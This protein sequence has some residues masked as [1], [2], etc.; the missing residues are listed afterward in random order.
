MKTSR[1][2]IRW[3]IRETMGIVFLGVALFVSAGSINWPMGWALLIITSLWVVGTALVLIPN[4]P[5]LIAERLGPRKGAKKWDTT[6][7]SVFGLTVLA[8]LVVAGLDIRFGWSEDVAFPLQLGTLVLAILANTLV[9]WATAA[10]AFFSQVVRIQEERA[11]QV[12]TGGPYRFVRHPGYVGTIL[13]ELAT[14]I[15]LGSWWALIPGC[16]GALLMLIRTA[17]EDHTLKD[18]LDGYIEYAETVR[19]RLVPGIW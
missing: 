7:V 19:Y 18:E 14:P 5:E 4:H 15:M 1:T 3:I 9:V 13:F 11:H 8:K 2:T 16:A 10:N 17:L 6:I 12:A